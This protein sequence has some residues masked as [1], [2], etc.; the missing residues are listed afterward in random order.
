MKIIITDK[1]NEIRELEYWC[2]GWDQTSDILNI[3][4]PQTY[5]YDLDAYEMTDEEYQ[6]WKDY[7]E[8][9]TECD[10][11]EAE[12]DDSG[13]VWELKD[14]ISG[15]LGD[16]PYEW[17]YILKNYLLV[18]DCEKLEDYIPPKKLNELKNGIDLKNERDLDEI[19]EYKN[20]LEKFVN[21]M[22]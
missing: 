2:D 18:R 1:D 7:I 15:E 12:I 3:G 17:K 22:E 4:E 16:Y 5:N 19:E 14:K 6:W 11:L 9:E 10:E 8:A 20:R 21:E 13:V